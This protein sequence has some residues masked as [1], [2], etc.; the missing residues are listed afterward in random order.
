MPKIDAEEAVR[1]LRRTKISQHIPIILI[2]ALN[3]GEL[4]GK[5]LKVDGFL[6]KPFN[7]ADL[8]S[9]VKKLLNR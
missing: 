4:I 5:S 1:L 8:T 3:E 7:I 9:L 2:S 6:K